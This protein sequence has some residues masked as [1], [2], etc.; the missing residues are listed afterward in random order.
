MD[1]SSMP[2]CAQ[3]RDIDLVAYLS[4]LGFEP[5]KIKGINFWYHSP[6]RQEHTPSFKVNR[7]LNRWYDFG[8]GIGGSIIDFAIRFH[9]CTIGEFLAS[10]VGTR[11]LESAGTATGKIPLKETPSPI[12]VFED[13]KLFSPPLLNYLHKRRISVAVADLLCRE[14]RFTLYGKIYYAIG[15]KN[16]SGG[17]ELRNKYF[18]GSSA[19]KDVTTWINGSDYLTVFEGFFDFLSYL[20]L[21]GQSEEKGDSDFLI[22]NS[23]SFFERARPVMESYQKTT[24]LLDNN[25][26]GD[27]FTLYGLSLNSCYADGRSFYKYYEDLNDF[28]CQFGSADK[29]RP[30]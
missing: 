3:A 18:K 15:F 4:G 24:L 25:R 11:P 13:R 12:T 23:L 28:L 14:V 1:F 17:F 29:F 21:M 30:P 7:N 16:D 26:A 19:P 5:A 2:T 27:R 20:V 22:L 6:F 10:L 8:E 9:Q